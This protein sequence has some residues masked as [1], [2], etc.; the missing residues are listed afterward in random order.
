MD[1][2]VAGGSEE[3]GGA[4]WA[5]TGGEL[6]RLKAELRR[7]SAELQEA[8]EQKVRAAECGLAVLEEKL[9]LKQRYCELE[10]QH[11]STKQELEH[12]KQAFAEAYSNHKKV[13]ADGETREE[14]LLRDSAKKEALLVTK[15]ME[16]QAEGRQAKLVVTN[17]VSDI[18][19]VHG[20]LQELRKK[21]E[22]VELEKS[23]LRQEIKELKVRESQHLQ[24][25]VD[26][27]E[28][29]ISLQKQVSTLKES[30]VEL[31][32][33]KHEIKQREEE[34][35]IL[36]GQLEAVTRLREIGEQH[37]DEALE[38]LKTE[39][40]QKNSLRKELSAFLNSNDSLSSVHINLEEWRFEESVSQDE[41]DSGYNHEGLRVST[42]Q[43]GQTFHPAPSLVSDL[44]TELNLSEVHK[45]RQQLQQVEAEKTS[46]VSAVQDLQGQLEREQR[47]KAEKLAQCA[48]TQLLNGGERLGTEQASTQPS[49]DYDVDVNG[50][51]VVQCKYRT[52]VRELQQLRAELAELQ[53]KYMECETQHQEGHQRQRLECEEL[54]GSLAKHAQSSQE[55]R[56]SIARLHRELRAS[57]KVAAESQSG[58][59]LAQ[60]ELVSLS[61]ELASLYHHVCMYNNLT[62]SRVMLDHFRGSSPHR[63]KRTS[64]LYCRRILSPESVPESGGDLSPRS[65]P[66][67]PLPEPLECPKEPMT[68]LN[69]SAVIRSQLKHLQVVV[70]VSRQRA[71]LQ[72]LSPEV[73]KDKQALVEEVLKLKSLLSTKR[74]QIATLRTVLKANKQTAEVAMANLKSKYDNEKTLV[75]E[76]MVKLRNELKA[77]K[78]DAATFSSLRSIF[79]SRCDQYVTQLDEMQR[80]LAAAEDEKKTLNSLLRM[81]IQQKLAL[82]Q[83]LEELDFRPESRHSRSKARARPLRYTQQQQN[84]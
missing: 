12:L 61:E 23:H 34:I 9:C 10:Q 46:L 59:S 75:S 50:L 7:L 64:D 27:E 38:T 1:V 72:L 56:D 60:E 19:C 45:L 73:E 14:T 17:A 22:Q 78:E 63:R 11:E 66:P 31:E 35:E 24:D 30:Q 41:L 26:L 44:L 51:E 5:D 53:V 84:I 68:I 18:E 33:L 52:V 57:S 43:A 49:E 48:E 81:A 55:D 71:A 40:E 20:E 70:E 15:V 67:S 79:A 4:V 83:R 29:N 65:L 80:Q 2:L 69:L 6:E 54:L 13:A 74:E 39:R 37:L 77:L 8:S 58:L 21:N 16:L 3:G 47:D 28:E 32:G 76:T 42:P 36:N 62:P 82:T 25:C